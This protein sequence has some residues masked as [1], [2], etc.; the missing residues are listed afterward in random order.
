MTTAAPPTAHST[1]PVFR[2]KPPVLT[3][4]L[5]ADE[6]A[7]PVLVPVVALVDADPLVEALLVLPVVPLPVP[8][9][10]AAVAVTVGAVAD[11]AVLA[12][13]VLTSPAVTVTAIIADA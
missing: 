12:G 8:A 13:A 10:E 7:A 1:F 4:E 11:A 6:D 2:G 3:E 9:V 5:P